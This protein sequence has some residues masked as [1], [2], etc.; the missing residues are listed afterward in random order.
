MLIE[1][2][3]LHL[4]H[5]AVDKSEQKSKDAGIRADKKNS[6]AGKVEKRF[7]VH[8]CAPAVQ[9]NNQNPATEPLGSMY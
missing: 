6:A 8:W 1:D 9:Q 4:P 5:G 3:E 7:V 2:D